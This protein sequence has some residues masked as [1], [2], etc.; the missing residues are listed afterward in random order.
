[1]K[2]GKLYS[3]ILLSFVL[4]LIVT[5]IMIFVLFMVTAGRIFH[6]RLERF[7]ASK[8][9]T[10]KSYVEDK[11]RSA[12][13]TPLVQNRELHNLVLF[14]GKTHDAKIWLSLPEGKPLIKSFHG[15]IP[16]EI[17][18]IDPQP[19]YAG[20]DSEMCC[21]VSKRH[22][23]HYASVSIK[24]GRAQNA[25]LHVLFRFEKKDVPHGAFALGLL[26]I[27][28]V[29]ALLIVPVS[30]RITNPL[31]HLKESVLR[32]AQGDLSHRADVPGNDEIAEL[33][34]SFNRMADNLE[35]MIRGGRELT[36]NISHEL[37]SPLARIRIASELLGDR[38]ESFNDDVIASRLE[39]IGEDI[40]ELDRLIGQIM[41]LSKLDI[42]QNP[43][44]QEIFDPGQL[45]CE[46]L[47][48]FRSPVEQKKL[49]IKTELHNNVTFTG[50][51]EA[52]RTGLSNI[53]DNAVKFSPQNGQVSVVMQPRG[54]DLFICVANRFSFLNDAELEKI[55]EPFYRPKNTEGQGTGLGLAITRKL[56]ERHG[57][58]IKA[59]N[60]ENGL[61]IEIFLPAI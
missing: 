56:I 7:I 31:R 9:L 51:R 3:K 10:A 30:R 39:D 61:S 21:F 16:K 57:G 36:A 46:L 14:L 26:G 44:K 6:S 8:M 4:V 2:F 17:A 59:A 15:N 19:V 27:G 60:S 41:M 20:Q 49:S 52:L 40:E 11:I 25:T 18:K 24:T 38:L 53:L 50:D 33:G 42:Q 12:P 32:I 34:S 23:F 47:E 55:F 22:R 48:R 54:G 37:R 13:Q 45:L 43:L 29:I 5:E 35:R 1:M 58:E 28:I